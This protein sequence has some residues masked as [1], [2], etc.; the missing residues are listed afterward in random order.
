M[1]I[2]LA[3]TPEFAVPIFEEIIKHFDVVGI[4]SQPD[5]ASQRG[6]KSIFTPTKNLAL[7]HNIKLFQPEKIVQIYDEL[8]ALQYD[9]LVTVAFGQ[10]IPTKILNIAKK[11]NVNVHGSLLPKYRG[12]APVQ[13]SVLNGDKK[14]GISIMEMVK[15]MDAGDVFVQAEVEISDDDT[16]LS[17]FNKLQSITV[18]NIVNWITLLDKG[19]LKRQKQDESQVSLS[20][21]LEKSDGEIISSMNVDYALR[22]IKAFNP[23][24][25]AFSYINQKRVKIFFASKKWVKNAP[26]LELKD[27][28]LYLIDYQFDS[29]KRVILQ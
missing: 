18:K 9:Y 14:T 12:A 29:K 19:V 3:G 15:E 2:L 8:I 21:K 1:K 16:S 25:I 6:R 4:V 20:P 24:P 28:V 26:T 27:G 10:F 13:Y 5:R 17:V 7:K 22:V 23:N 11:M